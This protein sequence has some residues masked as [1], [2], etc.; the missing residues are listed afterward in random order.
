MEV[1]MDSMNL[2][3]SLFRWAHIIAGVLWIGH[4]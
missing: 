2:L 3:E 4:L 1:F